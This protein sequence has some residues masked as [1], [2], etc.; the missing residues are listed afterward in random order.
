MQKIIKYLKIRFIIYIVFLY[1][2]FE[3]EVMNFQRKNKVFIV[4]LI[5]AFILSASVMRAFAATKTELEQ[6]RKDNEKQ[7]NDAKTQRENILNEMSG[8][9]KEVEAL[10]FQISGYE[11]EI[12]DMDSNIADIA[13]N[14]EEKENEL[15]RTQKDL[16]EKQKLL[17]KKLVASYKAGETSYLDFLLTSQDLTD[18]LAN[19]YLVEKLA[20]ADNRLID[21]IKQNKVTIEEAK[22]T[23]EE[24]KKQL[25][26]AR[27]TQANKKAALDV[28]KRERTDKVATLSDEEKKIQK[29]IEEMQAEDADIKAAIKKIEEEERKNGGKKPSVNP[30]GYIWPLPSAYCTITTGMWYSKD[31]IMKGRYHGAVDFGSG[32]IYGQPVY[33]VKDGTV[34]TAKN[35]TDS[36]GTHVIIDHHDGTCTIYG[37]GIRGSLA[38][39]EGQKVKQ[40]QTI[41]KVGNTGN[42]FG[43]HLHFE[44]RV[45]PYEWGNRVDPRNYLP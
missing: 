40:G 34:V 18:F 19:Y 37:H 7:I 26:V 35:K 11:N 27:E 9:Q 14:I 3:E 15:D 1:V 25:E 17:E 30:G 43:A 39:S 23:L 20:E 44:V 45:A 24:S 12:A 13:K 38:V 33:A 41:M 21:T 28:A 10:N 22:T 42:S 8:I 5:I 4:V 29:Q 36:Y 6:Q 31:G 2:S 16:E 32:G